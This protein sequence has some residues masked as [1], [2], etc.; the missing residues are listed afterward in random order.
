MTTAIPTTDRT[1]SAT[2]P[3][4]ATIPGAQETTPARAIPLS[5]VPV[6][7]SLAVPVLLR[8]K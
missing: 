8:K 5:L 2:P 1:T 7:V 3:V 6:L 4:T